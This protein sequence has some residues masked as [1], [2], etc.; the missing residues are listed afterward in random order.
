M[1]KKDDYYCFKATIL[2]RCVNSS[3]SLERLV[4][5]FLVHQWHTVVPAGRKLITPLASPLLSPST[6]LILLPLCLLFHCLLLLHYILLRSHTE[7]HHLHWP[8][9]FQCPP[10]LGRPAL[11][12]KGSSKRRADQVTPHCQEKNI[13]LGLELKLF[14][15]L[16]LQLHSLPIAPHNCLNSGHPGPFVNTACPSCCCPSVHVASSPG[17]LSLL[18]LYSN[19]PASTKSPFVP[20]HPYPPLRPHGSYPRHSPVTLYQ[21]SPQRTVNSLRAGTPTHSASNTQNK[22]LLNRCRSQWASQRP[23]GNGWMESF[24]RRKKRNWINPLGAPD[25][26]LVFVSHLLEW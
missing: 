15:V 8:P 23:P 22:H 6:S 14:A 2:E 20:P 17:K 1:S 26:A 11:P 18:K 13:L 16:F 25:S 12:P 3:R 19:S 21:A 24:W 7:Y 4:C 5:L 10:P 9:C